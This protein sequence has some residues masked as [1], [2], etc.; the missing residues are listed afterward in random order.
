MGSSLQPRLKNPFLKHRVTKSTERLALSFENASSPL[1]ALGASVFPFFESPIL[2]SIFTVNRQASHLTAFTGIN[3]A[4]DDHT[5]A[6]G[7]VFQ[8]IT[9]VKSQVGLF[10]HIDR[11]DTIFNP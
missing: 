10:T 8:R 6:V 7:R 5:D 9:I 2:R 1:C 11:T 4:V 3:N